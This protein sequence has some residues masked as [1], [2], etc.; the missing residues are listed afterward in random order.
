MNRT[1][2]ALALILASGKDILKD[3]FP[4]DQ[5][6]INQVLS[7]VVDAAQKKD[8]AR[9][10]ALH[11]YGPKF[12]KFEDDGLPRMGSDAAR[13][14]ERELANFKSVK[15]KLENLKVDVFGAVAVATFVIDYDVDTGQGKMA[16]K[17]RATLVF[18]KD[19]SAWRI[20][21]EHAS[22]LKAP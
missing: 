1:L 20:V 5:A 13:K 6:K 10:E 8:I 3:P 21:H 15:M 2:A 17:S 7:D 16:G 18:A 4:D 19:G 11:S 22:P 9:L 12:T 14:G